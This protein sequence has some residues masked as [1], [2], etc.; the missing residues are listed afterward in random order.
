MQ[1]QCKDT[2]I[3]KLFEDNIVYIVLKYSKVII[4]MK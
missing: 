4:I 1:L 3:N 2:G